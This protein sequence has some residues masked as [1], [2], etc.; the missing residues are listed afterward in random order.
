MNDSFQAKEMEEAAKSMLV[1]EDQK[2]KIEKNFDVLRLGIDALKEQNTK[3]TADLDNLL[4]Q[5]DYLVKEEGAVTAENMKVGLKKLEIKSGEM[6][7]IQKKVNQYTIKKVEPISLGGSWADYWDNATLYARENEVDFKTDPFEQLMSPQQQQAIIDKMKQEYTAEKANCDRYDY[8]L[9]SVSGV[10]S[11]FI[12]IFF[13]GSP[14]NQKQKLL[15]KASDDFFRE[16]VESFADLLVSS[17]GKFYSGK[18][19]KPDTLAKKIQYLEGRFKVPYDAVS[20]RKL[21]LNPGT[22][23]MNTKNHHYVSLAHSPGIEGLVFA[24]IDQLTGQGTYLSNGKL[25]R[26]AYG[27]KSGFHLEGGNFIEKIF[28]AIVNWLGHLMSDAIGSN[29][30]VANGSRGTGLPIPLMQFFQMFN[31]VRL[32]ICEDDIAKMARKSFEDGYDLRHGAALAIPVVI[33]ELLIRFLWM[34]KQYFYHGKD[35]K[36]ILKQSQ[37]PELRRMLLVGHGNLCL[38][39]GTDAASRNTGN[40]YAMFLSM[41]FVA[42]TRFAYAGFTEV[43]AIYENNRAANKQ[44]AEEMDAEWKLLLKES[45]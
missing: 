11:G 39:D 44:R 35:I 34:A 29:T 41:N 42:W 13:V 30:S 6:K 43:R 40:I 32:P 25:V 18:S 20:D 36:S 33:N 24:I 37:T 21:D 2:S 26:K 27:T 14:L 22:L 31:N 1:Q 12:D 23:N 9:S 5:A 3:N 38:V 10:L 4:D 16:K 45:T 15:A 7:S 17:D 8:L 28:F 19:K